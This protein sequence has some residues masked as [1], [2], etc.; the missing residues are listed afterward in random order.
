MRG[1]EELQLEVA[2]CED[3][4][5][6]RE[7]IQ[8]RILELRPDYA[9]DTYHIGEDV[10]LAKKSYDII[11]LDIEMPGKDGMTIAKELRAQKYEGH[12]IFLTSHTEFMPD[13]FKVKA[14]R[15]LE[16]PI[17]MEDLEETL[18]ES[19][20]EIFVEKKVILADYGAEVLVNLSDILYIEAQ[21]NKTVVYTSREV[22]ETNYTLKY[23]LQE[24]GTVDFF[25]V[26]KSYIVS[27]RHIRNVEVNCVS[28]HGTDVK[29]PVSRRNASV[30]KN[31]FFNYIKM[32]AKF[33]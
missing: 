24:L 28:L 21:K 5:I 4:K 11:F 26:H 15:F 33:M 9:I 7:D 8:R 32:N 17:Q 31:V 18:T 27:L 2:I 30:V 23:W 25:Q 22:V 13:A 14:F 29:V 6:M 20:K 19:E 1:G 12:I 10:L 16:K 3:D